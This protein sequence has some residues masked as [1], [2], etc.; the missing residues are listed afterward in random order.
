MQP[1]C[2]TGNRFDGGNPSGERSTRFIAWLTLVVMVVEIAAGYVFNSMALTA[3]GWHMGTHAFALGLSAFAYA[4]ARRHAND[5]RFA[6][7]TW[8]VEV[9]GGYTSALLLLLVVATMIFQSVE[10]FMSPVPIY[11]TEAIIVAIVGLFVNVFSAVLLH[12]S[13][14]HHHGVESEEGH[15]HHHDLNLHSAYVHVV[16]DAA[17]SVLAIIALLGGMWMGWLWLDPLVGILGAIMIAFWARGLLRDTTNVLLDAEMTSTAVTA[18]R[19]AMSCF[20][21]N[22]FHAWRI[23]SQHYAVI[24][25]VPEVYHADCRALLSTRPEVAHL[26]LQATPMIKA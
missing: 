7:G 26:T 24:V 19:D 11:F 3:D 15:H 18:I 25:C 13:Q 23:G 22:D 1:H 8:K 17:T 14:G 10:R 21:L 9:L 2:A 12:R 20:P 16:T 4:Y 5:A 6:F